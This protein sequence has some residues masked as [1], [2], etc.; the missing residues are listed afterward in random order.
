MMTAWHLYTWY[1][2]NR[3]CGACGEKTVHDGKERMMRCEKCGNM[4]FPRI[5][6]AVIIALTHGDKLIL[7]QYAGR[8]T[9]RYGLLAGFIEIGETAEDTVRRFAEAELKENKEY[10]SAQHFRVPIGK[11]AYLDLTLRKDD[12]NV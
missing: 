5:A 4:I 3:F 11:K 8:G 12:K 9:T 1:R 7:S 2:V 6:P 10:E